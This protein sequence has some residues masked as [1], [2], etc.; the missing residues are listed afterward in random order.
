MI[1]SHFSFSR[2][3]PKTLLNTIV[4]TGATTCAIFLKSPRSNAF[5]EPFDA[6]VIAFFAENIAPVC[7]VFAHASYTYNL[8]ASGNRDNNLAA[9]LHECELANQLGVPIIIHPGFVE[10]GVVADGIANVV[11]AINYI[12]ARLPQVTVLVEFCGDAPITKKGCAYIGVNIGQIKKILTKVYNRARVGVCLDTCHMYVAGIDMND[13]ARVDAF[14]T[15]F[16][17]EIGA[18]NLQLIHLNNTE[19]LLGSCK[20]HHSPLARGNITGDGFKHFLRHSLIRGVPIVT[21]T[22]LDGNAA[23]KNELKYVEALLQ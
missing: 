21:E 1:G 20:D 19:E 5:V 13:A 6:K 23:I 7:R 22:H 10:S 4:A 3:S 12:H 8:A 2:K 17:T 16:D 14:M 11:A 15:E 9:F 18:A